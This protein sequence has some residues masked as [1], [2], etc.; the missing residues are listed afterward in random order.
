MII[1]PTSWSV[2][3]SCEVIKAIDDAVEKIQGLS[4]CRWA[5]LVGKI[6]EPFFNWRRRTIM[7]WRNLKI[8]VVIAIIG[9]FLATL[10]PS[11]AFIQAKEVTGANTGSGA[12][13]STVAVT[14]HS[15]GTIGAATAITAAAAAAVAVASGTGFSESTPGS[16]TTHN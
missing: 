16:T 4:V 1:S 14:G 2:G 15:A 11:V 6:C 10:I 13:P 7:R 8:Y 12:G 5:F 3:W 9:L